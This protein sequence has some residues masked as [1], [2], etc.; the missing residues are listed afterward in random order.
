MTETN[1]LP[2][3]AGLDQATTL[4]APVSERFHAMDSVRAAAM[5]LGV[6][7]HLPT[8]MRGGFGMFGGGPKASIDNW[9]HSFRMPMFFL[10][11]GFFANMM[12]RKYGFGRYL[13]RRWWRIGAPLFVSLIVF[14]CIRTYFPSVMQPFGGGMEMA[15]MGMAP[16]Q[17]GF[18]TPPA[19]QT[20]AG[21]MP[22][23]PPGG[24]PTSPAPFAPAA[25][26]TPAP[27]G[28]PGTF[29]PTQPITTPAAPG[30][31]AFPF[32]APGF[33][34]PM[35]EMPAT[36]SH[37]WA[38]GWFGKYA[39]NFNL[40]HL[41]FLW[42]LL[43]FVTLGPLVAGAIARLTARAS[44][45]AVDEI[46]HEMIRWHVAALVLGLLSLPALIHARNFMGWSLANPLGFSAGFPDFL[47]QYHA[48]W[49]FY[50]IYFLAGWCFYRV[51]FG[52]EYLARAWKWNLAIGI[53]GFAFSQWLSGRYSFQITAANYAWIR[54]AAFAMNSV[55]TAYTSF[56]FIGL[57]QKFL[58]R[59]TPIGRY[60]ADTALWIYLIHLPLIPLVLEW[61]EP[62]RSAWW[63]ATI[64]GMV[65][66][67]G[68]ALILFELFIRP[69]PLV[70][71]FGPPVRRR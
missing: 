49:P 60:L 8:G 53:C 27:G 70:H 45:R 21:G 11:S 68:C 6:F 26:L 12:L 58:N 10:I 18:M 3:D 36:P 66:V 42:Y 22:W 65:V 51:R 54:I 57:F 1:T 50:F 13:A 14:G 40:E 52:L 67:T 29:A 64:A 32:G 56:G 33:M 34:P 31:N 48:D 63:S 39:A 55:G 62:S 9:L 35:L 71:I 23:G 61:T 28:A 2:A 5:L 59:P 46:A 41:W 20:P 47:F 16:P 43:V 4:A 19:G 69:T 24:W 15:G 44:H 7:Y 38:N 37:A 25:P 17:G 30:A